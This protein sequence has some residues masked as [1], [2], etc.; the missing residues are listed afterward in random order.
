[1]RV[2]IYFNK[3]YLSD[4][5]PYVN[6]LSSALKSGGMDCQVID[7]F[8]DLKG[9][10]VIFVLGGDGTILNIASECS[11]Y[12]VKIIGI[13]YGH[14]GFLAEFGREKIDEAVNLLLSGEFETQKRS[15]LEIE[16]GDK[17][18]LALNDLVVQRNTS[19]GGF[20]NT[21]SLRTEIDG[22]TVD[23]ITADGIIISTPTG[24]TAYSLSAGGSI[25]TPDLNAFIMTPI[26][27][28]SLHSRPIVYNDKSVL[29]IFSSENETP[30]NIVVDGK[31][32]DEI[33]GKAAVKVKKAEKCV[34]FITCGEKDFFKKLLIKL[35]IWSR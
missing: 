28:H 8:S 1:M 23:I 13:N 25:L 5:L 27:A 16:H 32:V 21:V 19:G 11:R 24:S 4:N 2:G 33:N 6:M 30:L 10:D 22:S 18:F 31:V 20:S 15:M 35:G 17:K 12:S 9:L 34:E 26:C 14:L 3:S 7:G 29:E